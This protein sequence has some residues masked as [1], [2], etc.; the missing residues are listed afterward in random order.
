MSVARLSSQPGDDGIGRDGVDADVG[1]GL[2]VAQHTAERRAVEDLGGTLLDRVAGAA[3]LGFGGARREVRRDRVGVDGVEQ[4]G[5]DVARGE[6]TGGLGD[7][8]AVAVAV[9]DPAIEGGEPGGQGREDG[10]VAT[11][12]GDVFDELVEWGGALAVERLG[13]GFQALGDADGVDQ[14]E[15]GLG[16]GVGGDGAQAFGGD[17]AGAA[18]FHLLEI[19][20]G[21]DVAEE[22]ECFE[23][24]DVGAGGDHVDGDRDARVEIVAEG[25]D[26]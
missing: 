6:A 11:A 15:A 1:G 14:D 5:G 22:D 26:Q 9:A 13:N 24:F 4:P 25:A 10:V 7:G 20:F 3:L 19:E 17:G 8:E 21:A 16:F 23:R 2:R 12:G 18:A